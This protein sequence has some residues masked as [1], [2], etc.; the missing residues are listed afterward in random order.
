MQ[1][2]NSSE[3][4]KQISDDDEPNNSQEETTAATNNPIL[5]LDEERKAA[6]R[7]PVAI[8]DPDKHRI[9]AAA[10]TAAAGTREASNGIGIPPATALTRH[11]GPTRP[12]SQPGAFP[13]RSSAGASAPGTTTNNTNNN[14]AATGLSSQQEEQRRRSGIRQ[15]FGSSGRRPSHEEEEES[16]RTGGPLIE[17]TLVHEQNVVSTTTTTTELAHAEP[18]WSP[19]ERSRYACLLVCFVVAV[20]AGVSAAV[21][22]GLDDIAEGDDGN[23][24]IL[25]GVPTAAPTTRLDDSSDSADDK[26]D[27]T[28][29]NYHAVLWGSATTCDLFNQT[30]VL[31][32]CVSAPIQVVNVRQATCERLSRRRVACDTFFAKEQ[33]QQGAVWVQCNDVLTATAVSRRVEN[34]SNLIGFDD[35]VDVL[36]GWGVTYTSLSTLCNDE[37]LSTAICTEGVQ[38][39]GRNRTACFASQQ[40]ETYTL[41][42]DTS[43]AMNVPPVEALTNITCTSNVTENVTR[44]DELLDPLWDE[45]ATIVREY[46]EMNGF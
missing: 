26:E 33:V 23:D 34:C 8:E 32:N 28:V 45:H 5:D 16:E 21:V 35:G 9:A 2:N 38:P 37:L 25:F 36:G 30:R 15:I 12:P 10:A 41:T 29:A 18:T 6:A 39:L 27:T 19:E 44:L 24:D 42:P 22:V 43:C 7:F 11:T 3:T 14:N 20:M 4:E 1:K 46:R 13:V 40:C 17:A 31:L